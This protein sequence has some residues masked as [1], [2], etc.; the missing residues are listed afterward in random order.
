MSRLTRVADKQKLDEE[1]CAYIEHD[2]A[3]I[4]AVYLGCSL[5]IDCRPA[6]SVWHPLPPFA[7]CWLLAGTTETRSTARCS[8][9]VLRIGSRHIGGTTAAA[10]E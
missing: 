2:S 1:V 7:R 3:V 10:C 8:L 4:S 6:V 5:H 9:T